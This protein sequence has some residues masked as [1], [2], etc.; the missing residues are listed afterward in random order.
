MKYR[1]SFYKCKPAKLIILL[2]MIISC[3]FIVSCT[4]R[5]QNEIIVTELSDA[6][7]FALEFPLV[8]NDNLFVYRTATETADILTNGR[9]IVFMGFKDCPWCHPY[10]VF[11]N[12]VAQEMGIEKIYYCDIREDRQNNTESYQRILEILAN[13][14]GYDDEGRQ[15]VFVPDLTIVSRGRIITR[16]YMTVDDRVGYDT[17]YEY[18]NEDRVDALKERL[19]EGIDILQRISGAC[20]LC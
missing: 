6:E 15:R 4:K 5:N 16:D 3:I 17:P 9:G 2:L 12:N 8:G 10:V 11:L 19:R 14:L 7:R 18:W 13:R 20:N 1:I